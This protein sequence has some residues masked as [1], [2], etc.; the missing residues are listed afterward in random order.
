M[1]ISVK[2]FGDRIRKILNY[3]NYGYLAVSVI[4]QA[5][6]TATG[7]SQMHDIFEWARFMSMHGRKQARAPD[8]HL[9]VNHAAAT[10]SKTRAAPLKSQ[11]YQIN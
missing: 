6:I 4:K 1:D 2:Y 9:G 8:H 10:S 11:R 5:G 7:P 3:L